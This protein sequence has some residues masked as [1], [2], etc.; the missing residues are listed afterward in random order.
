MPNSTVSAPEMT[1]MYVP[2]PGFAQMPMPRMMGMTQKKPLLPGICVGMRRYTRST[3]TRAASI[4]S[5]TM[6][7][8]VKYVR[9]EEF[10]RCFN[11]FTAANA[12]PVS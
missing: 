11:R 1:P 4:V 5:S 3:K 7:Y 12:L 6:S 10:F 2:D 8:R 9:R